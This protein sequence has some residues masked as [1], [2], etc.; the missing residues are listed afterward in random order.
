M[1]LKTYAC[2]DNFVSSNKLGIPN[3]TSSHCHDTIN[4]LDKLLQSVAQRTE[5]NP[6]DAKRF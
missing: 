4:H 6:A 2:Y 5:V 3:L 1:E